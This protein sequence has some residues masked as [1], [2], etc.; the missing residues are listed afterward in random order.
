MLKRIASASI[1]LVKSASIAEV[2]G[3]FLPLK[4]AGANL[5]ACCPFHS[6][7]S[8]SFI[9]SPAK[10]IYKCF[11]CGAGGDAIRFVMEHEKLDFIKAVETVA[12]ILSGIPWSTK[13]VNPLKKKLKPLARPK[14]RKRFWIL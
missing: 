7:K 2:V 3:H 10:D 5:T 6:E 11:G 8:P 12:S 14:R 13:N 9:V 4:K 1:E